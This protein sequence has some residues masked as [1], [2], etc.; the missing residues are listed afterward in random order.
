MDAPSPD[1]LKP[2]QALMPGLVHE[3]RNPLS[4]VLAGG[5]ML[6][7]LLE[8]KHP[9]QEYAEIVLEEARVLERFVARL[10]QFGRIRAVDPASAGE[11]DLPALLRHVLTEGHVDRDEGKIRLETDFDT[12]AGGVRGDPSALALACSE[13]LR[14]ALEAMPEGGTLS[15]STRLFTGEAARSDPG[16]SGHGRRGEDAGRIAAFSHRPTSQSPHRVS[17]GWIEAEFADTGPGMT[18]EIRRRAFEPFFSTRPRALGIGLSLAQ[19]IALA[20]GARIRL[21]PATQR[22]A[23]V[24]LALPAMGDR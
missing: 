3:F 7:R 17:P 2:L 12:R 15:I 5:Q 13:I 10:A 11:V 9:A 24:F 16:T 22:G 8:A 21:G 14:N 23:S 1:W 19:A 18:E 20:H 6:L 4:G